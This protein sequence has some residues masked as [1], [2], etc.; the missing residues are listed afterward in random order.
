MISYVGRGSGNCLRREDRLA[1]FFFAGGAYLGLVVG[2]VIPFSSDGL[3]HNLVR[4]VI[5]IG[6]LLLLVLVPPSSRAARLATGWVLVV[7][8]VTI[9]QILRSEDPRYALE[10][11]EALVFGTCVPFFLAASAIRRWGVRA[12]AESFV[13]FGMILL[14]ATLLYKLHYGLFDRSVRFFLNGPIVFGWMMGFLSLVA[15]LQARWEPR[16]WNYFCLVAFMLAMIWTQSKGPLIAYALTVVLASARHAKALL[17][18]AVLVAFAMSVLLLSSPAEHHLAESSRL[19]V[20][21]DPDEKLDASEHYGSVGVRA[22]MLKAGTQLVAEYPFI[23]I[24]LG[25]WEAYTEF[26]FKYPHNQH[27]EVLVEL[28]GGVFLIYLGG[29]LFG[30]LRSQKVVPYF[31]FFFIIAGLFSGDIAYLRYVAALLILGIY[32]KESRRV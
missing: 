27:L 28:G 18:I 21:L 11:V 14:F 23:G 7:G 24:G 4:V 8:F 20:L 26:G 6:S 29:L 25:N 31:A 22:D 12:F 10:K 3:T 2:G 15:G 32:L 30:M 19:S 5:F 13:A 17:V 1:L 16:L 9:P